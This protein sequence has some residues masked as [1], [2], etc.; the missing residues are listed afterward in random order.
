MERLSLADAF[1]KYGGKSGHSLSAIA[2]DGA[3]ILGCSNE[4][5]C[6]PSA[7]VLRY[8]D[9]VSRD[10][11]TAGS[12]SVVPEHLQLAREGSLPVRLVVVTNN[13]SER[14][15]AKRHAHVRTDLIGNLVEFD[16]DRYVVDFV[17]TGE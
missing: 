14:G 4:R 17:K 12:L 13:A 8:E 11:S 7:G 16:G 6:R 5:F 9:R 1:A 10:A 2:K 3:I 15:K